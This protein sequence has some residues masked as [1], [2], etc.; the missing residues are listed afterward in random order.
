MIREMLNAAK[1]NGFDL[2]WA[3]QL[4]T[5][6]ERL[7]EGD[8]GL[9]LLDLSLPDSWGLE[10]FAKT[11]AQAPRVPIIVLI[12]HNDEGMAVHAVREGAQGYLAKGQGEHL[13]LRGTFKIWPGIKIDRRNA[14]CRTF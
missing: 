3:E 12:G 9:V 10:T 13:P 2:E 14:P 11:S 8:I 7:A 4:Y 5:G 6:L 1:G